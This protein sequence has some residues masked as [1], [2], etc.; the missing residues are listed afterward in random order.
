MFFVCV[1]AAPAP[2][3][4]PVAAAVPVTVTVT[5]AVKV[6][7]AVLVPIAAAIVEAAAMAKSVHLHAEVVEVVLLLR[8]TLGSMVIVHVLL[9]RVA[10]KKRTHPCRQEKRT[11][12]KSTAQVVQETVTTTRNH[13]VETG[14]N[15]GEGVPTKEDLG[16]AKH[17]TNT[18]DRSAG[19]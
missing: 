8:A 3:P 10:R 16:K 7:A 11:P 13:M 9:P 12:K 5:T 14:T 18:K 15:V 17:T 2:A 4:A 1:I 19:T 6:A